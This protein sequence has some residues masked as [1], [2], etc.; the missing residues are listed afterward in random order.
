MK[1]NLYLP[2]LLVMLGWTNLAFSQANASHIIGEYWIN[3]QTG[4]IQIFE[5][6][7]QY[8]GKIIWREEVIK[9]SKNP[10]PALRDRSVIGIEF[11]KNFEFDGSKYKG[12]T[13]YSI[14]NGKTYA[15]KLW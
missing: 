5:R 4:K 1:I 2:L 6:Q 13:V 12:G 14:E 8:F 15:G 10:D 9:D 3:N 11:I 7:G